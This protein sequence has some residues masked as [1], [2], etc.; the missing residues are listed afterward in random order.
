MVFAQVTDFFSIDLGNIVA[1]L[2][3]TLIMF[4]VIKHFLFKPVNNILEKRK[5]EINKTYQEADEIK[6]EA[7]KFKSE[8]TEKLNGAE[9][10]SE[11]IIN[12]ARERANIISEEIVGEAKQEAT[13]LISKA[14][15]QIEIEKKKAVNDIKN[16]ITGM[17]FEVAEKVVEKEVSTKDNEK[18]IEEFINS[19]GEPS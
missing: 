15:T 12:S 4:L 2:I 1:T 18:L 19:V 9:N 7:E 8:Y 11:N 6:L 10:E 17:V 13:N 16:E 3:N 5:G 14:N